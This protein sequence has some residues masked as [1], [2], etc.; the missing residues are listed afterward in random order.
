[1]SSD[2]IFARIFRPFSTQLHSTFLTPLFSFMLIFDMLSPLC[3][4]RSQTDDKNTFNWYYWS[5]NNSS[6]GL[7]TSR[8]SPV[9]VPPHLDPVLEP[10][11]PPLNTPTTQSSRLPRHGAQVGVCPPHEG[12]WLS[13][14][15]LLLPQQDRPN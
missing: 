4:S 3:L 12:S 5:L 10:P 13:K 6:T 2:T 14:G 9:V 7:P 15:S 11:P 1:M 8:N